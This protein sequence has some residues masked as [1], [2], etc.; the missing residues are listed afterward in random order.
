MPLAKDNILYRGAKISKE[1]ISKIKNYDLGALSLAKDNILYRGAKI[2]RDE[3]NKLKNYEK[4]KID[5]LPYAIVFSRSFL[6]FSKDKKVAKEF[7]RQGYCDKNIFRVLYKLEKDD[8][9]EY[10]LATHSDIEE[11]A[12]IRD[13]KEVLFFPFSSF[14]VK[15]IKEINIDKE[16]GYEIHLLYLGKYLKEIEND[17]NITLN[18][19]KLPDSEFKK[20]LTESNLIKKEKI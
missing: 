10:N 1:E 9:S 17:K 14:E 12:L 3:I 6:S 2:S 5:N 20:Q 19:I 7:L 18:E 4:K 13:E 15:K 11:I 8:K 16:K